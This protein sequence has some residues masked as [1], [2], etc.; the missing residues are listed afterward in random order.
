MPGGNDTTFPGDFTF[1]LSKFVEPDITTDVV[2]CSTALY[3][4]HGSSLSMVPTQDKPTVMASQLQQ[5]IPEAEHEGDG[6]FHLFPTEETGVT[7]GNDMDAAEAKDIERTFDIPTTVRD[8]EAKTEEVEAQ[9]GGEM[10]EPVVGLQT[11]EVEDESQPEAE[12]QATSWSEEAPATGSRSEGAGSQM[13]N[14]TDY[15]REEESSED[16]S[17]DSQG[18]DEHDETQ[19]EEDEQQKSQCA[20]EHIGRQAHRSEGGVV[21]VGEAGESVDDSEKGKEGQDMS[22]LLLPGVFP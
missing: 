10:E 15:E 12:D 2:N 22:C 6:H 13:E 17:P 16:P 5:Q 7:S 11:G 20:E 19:G 21:P 3:F 4:Q 14:E 9:E 18:E 1:G 8:D